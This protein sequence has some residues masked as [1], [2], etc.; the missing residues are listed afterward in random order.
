MFWSVGAE[1]GTSD[2]Q[3]QPLDRLFGAPARRLEPDK[4]LQQA[5]YS[6]L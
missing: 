5:V 1:L 6:V 3:L 4:S 2:N